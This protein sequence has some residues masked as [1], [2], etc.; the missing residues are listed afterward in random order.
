VAG[1]QAARGAALPARTA[2]GKKGF[3]AARQA[4]GA[5]AGDG[6]GHADSWE[7]ALVSMRRTV[8]VGLAAQAANDAYR[9]GAEVLHRLCQPFF[10][11]TAFLRPLDD[12]K[13]A[14]A[15]DGF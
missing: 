5:Q 10:R 8:A 6:V 15:F 7:A 11:R 3:G 12:I 1:N 13:V 4:R 2:T 14:I 9:D